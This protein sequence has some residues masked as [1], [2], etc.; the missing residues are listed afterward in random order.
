[1]IAR[2]TVVIRGESSRNNNRLPAAKSNA[3]EQLS[4]DPYAFPVAWFRTRCKLG[5]RGRFVS[6]FLLAL[7]LLL[8]PLRYLIQW[9]GMRWNAMERRLLSWDRSSNTSSKG[10]FLDAGSG[11]LNRPPAP[12]IC[13][14][15]TRPSTHGYSPSVSYSMPLLQATSIG[16]FRWYVFEPRVARNLSDSNRR[17]RSVLLNT[18]PFSSGQKKFS[19]IHALSRRS[20]R[21]SSKFWRAFSC[22]TCLSLLFFTRYLDDQRNETTFEVKRNIDFAYWALLVDGW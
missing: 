20:E 21:P 2:S 18:S 14:Q 12:M 16:S 4:V 8:P 6:R 11:F 15:C 10:A 19:P 13:V 22:L 9:D 17:S 1:M 7:T 5:T 3:S